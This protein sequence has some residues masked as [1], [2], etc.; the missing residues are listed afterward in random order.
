MKRLFALVTALSA[1]LI[2]SGLPSSYGSTVPSSAHAGGA[3]VALA[4]S[5]LG[6]ILVDGK[7]RTLY[8]FPPDKHGMS[9]CYGAC[10]A[11][12]AAHDARQAGRGPRRRASCWAPR[13]VRMASWR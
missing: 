1:G 13:S 7:G 12:A 5:P 8:D 2:V 11:P 6:R 10:A 3:T 4:K 9:T